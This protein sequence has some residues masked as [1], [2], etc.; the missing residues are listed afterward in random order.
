M[1]SSEV[2]LGL[3][4]VIY[5]L[6]DEER[7]WPDCLERL[8]VEF[9]L[10]AARIYNRYKKLEFLSEEWCA[11]DGK[12]KPAAS[13]A[14]HRRFILAE[15]DAQSAWLELERLETMGPLT[16]VELARVEELVPHLQRV[17][18]LLDE[19]RSQGTEDA[20]LRQMLDASDAA[21]FV[22]N[23]SLEILLQ[24]RAATQFHKGQPM[25][26]ERPAFSLGS[27]GGDEKLREAIAQLGP[28]QKVV[29]L[30]LEP[31]VGQAPLRVLVCHARL[32]GRVFR[33]PTTPAVSLILLHGNAVPTLDREVFR[34]LFDFSPAEMDVAEL[35]IA[36]MPAQRIATQLHVSV[37]TVRS[38]IQ[39]LLSKS[40]TSQ[41]SE[42][43]ALALRIGPTVL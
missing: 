21:V 12:L 8:V 17:L 27:K 9:Q 40:G 19:R 1:P 34:R 5:S 28:D 32:D 7:Q 18:R 2:R 25:G 38:H 33:L 36:G 4:E 14:L 23:H 29:S 42:F 41:Q 37:H 16:D 43:V 22:L 30:Y 13:T 39:S 15:S 11:T 35:L 10:T 31:E 6:L 24:N 26:S 20:L 3:P